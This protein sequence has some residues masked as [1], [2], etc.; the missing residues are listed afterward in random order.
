MV[1]DIRGT[2]G[3]PSRASTRARPTTPQ[4]RPTF[5]KPGGTSFCSC[6]AAYFAA[7]A[8]AAVGLRR[9]STRVA[10]LLS[11]PVTSAHAWE[12]HAFPTHPSE[13]MWKCGAPRSWNSSHHIQV[14][15]AS[16]P[17]RLALSMKARRCLFTPGPVRG[18][19][20]PYVRVT[21]T[22]QSTRALSSV[23]LNLRPVPLEKPRIDARS[24]RPR[25]DSREE[26]HS[27]PLTYPSPT[28]RRNHVIRLP[29]LPWSCAHTFCLS[30]A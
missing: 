22:R 29:S 11:P 7:Y 8:P 21:I 24:A 2:R 13:M 9:A 10:T 1:A 15:S 16:R 27:A 28:F 3:R 26:T 6:L 14:F 20:A 4:N 17:A 19:S 5:S 23:C 30:S 12:S 18:Q 25:K